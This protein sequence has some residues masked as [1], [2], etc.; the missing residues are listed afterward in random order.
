M[1]LSDAGNLIIQ[2]PYKKTLLLCRFRPVNV[3][4][5]CEAIEQSHYP[6]NTC[7]PVDVPT[8]D[9]YLVQFRYIFLI[10]IFFF[11]CVSKKY[12]VKLLSLGVSTCCIHFV[13]IISQTVLFGKVLNITGYSKMYYLCCK[14][15][16]WKL[17]C[18]WQ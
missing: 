4:Y 7:D 15:T 5:G 16:A 9:L 12:L 13:I 6:Y 17:I 18:C 11:E 3:V 2:V 14:Y 8:K 10:I 1:V